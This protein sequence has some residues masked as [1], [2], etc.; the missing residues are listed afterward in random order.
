MTLIE[1]VIK[2][3][4]PGILIFTKHH[5]SWVDVHGDPAPEL[6]EE[7]TLAYFSAAFNQL[8]AFSGT[9]EVKGSSI[10]APVIVSKDTGAMR[11]GS[12]LNFEYKF[13]GDMLV[14][15]LKAWNLELK[16]KRVE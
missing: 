1:T 7:A 16:M 6:P 14:L 8:T 13:E 2:N 5:F 12:V 11:D 9:Y 10:T 3:H 15:T 4:R